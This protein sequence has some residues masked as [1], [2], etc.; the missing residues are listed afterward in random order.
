ME[1]D[2]RTCL[3]RV[4]GRKKKKKKKKKTEKKTTKKKKKKKKGVGGEAVLHSDKL[5][6][7]ASYN[8][9]SHVK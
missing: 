4:G 6:S 7:S 1:S 3:F 8:Q 2:N 5:E 9:R